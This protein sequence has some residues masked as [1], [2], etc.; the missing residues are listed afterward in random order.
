ME[1]N[2]N[3]QP[4]LSSLGATLVANGLFD[5]LPWGVLVLD[6]Q[7]L[8]QHVNQQAARWCG[9]SP[10][11]LLGRPL[12]EADLPAAIGATL[13]RL[14]EPGEA[15]AREV[16]LPEQEQWIALSATHQPGGWVLYGQDITPQK[17]REAEALSLQAELA[18]R[19][20]DQYHALFHSM[21]QGFCVLE[22]LF[23]DTGQHVVDFRYQKLNPVFSRQ[24]GIPEGALGKTARELMPDLDPFWFNTYGR[25]VLTGESVRLEH[26]VPQVDRWIDAHIFRVGGPETRQVA[27]LFNDIT[28]RKQAEEQLRSAAAAD[29]FRLLL[30]DALGP[31]SDPVALQEAV[32]HLTRQHFEADRC[33]YVEIEGDQ[34]IIRR[35]AFADGMPSVAGTY[36]LAAYVLLQAVIEAGLPSQRARRARG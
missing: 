1:T 20:T 5:A 22:I 11:A 19:T 16:Y 14:L 29:A 12:A 6:E 18:Q 15:P 13:Q 33:Y 25:V 23:D 28:A 3:A 24:S 17:Q 8:V 31:L 26:Y 36:P 2:P 35:D 7:H 27:V 10:E 21:D 9:T 32:T 4:N 34:G 30:A